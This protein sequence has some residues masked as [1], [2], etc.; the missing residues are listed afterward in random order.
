[1]CYPHI[2][3]ARKKRLHR[4]ARSYY[5]QSITKKKNFNTK[6][7]FTVYHKTRRITVMGGGLKKND[8]HKYISYFLRF[9]STS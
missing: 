8:S 1:M 3:F 2:L 9:P 4:L 6:S 5:A 7:P